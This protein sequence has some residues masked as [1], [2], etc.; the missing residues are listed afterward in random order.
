MLGAGPGAPGS[1]FFIVFKK[2]TIGKCQGPAPGLPGANSVLFL[3][4]ISFPSV[5]F[6][7]TNGVISNFTQYDVT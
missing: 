7:D 1:S 6:V 3:L 2:K 5:Q 4:G